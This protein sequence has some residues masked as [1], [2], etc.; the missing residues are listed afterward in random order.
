MTAKAIHQTI[1]SSFELSGDTGIIV[2]WCQMLTAD[3]RAMDGPEK[4]YHHC[5]Q[6]PCADSLNSSQDSPQAMPD[7]D[8][9]E[10]TQRRKHQNRAAQKRFSEAAYSCSFAVANRGPQENEL[11]GARPA[12]H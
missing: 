7:L 6:T 9:T 11:E 3:V 4:L 10:A 8:L 1:D 5:R 2:L 12:L